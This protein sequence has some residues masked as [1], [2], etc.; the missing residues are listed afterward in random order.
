MGVRELRAA[1]VPAIVLSSWFEVR[2]EPILNLAWSW[3]SR[4]RPRS[5]SSLPGKSALAGW[6]LPRLSSP[7]V[8]RL[9]YS[10]LLYT[11]SAVAVVRHVGA[12]LPLYAAIRIR[13]YAASRASPP[14]TGPSRAEPGTGRPAAPVPVASSVVAD[15]RRCLCIQRVRGVFKRAHPLSSSVGLR[16]AFFFFF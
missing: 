7:F 8:F 10:T 16:F 3:Y 1:H 15:I 12:P 9:L 5:R 11:D 4:V 14:A 2:E 6:L 13:W